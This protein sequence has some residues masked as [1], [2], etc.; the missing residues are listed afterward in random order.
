MGGGGTDAGG[1]GGQSGAGTDAGSGGVGGAVSL[2]CIGNESVCGLDCCG[3]GTCD[4][5]G[6]YTF[7]LEPEADKCKLTITE[8]G[9]S[10]ALAIMACDGSLAAV[11][12]DGTPNDQPGT[13]TGSGSTFTMSI[14]GFDHVC[15]V[16]PK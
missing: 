3:V 10:G 6:G 7:K 13:W 1:E 15:V 16:K 8:S 4:A 5:F 14:D 12:P 2:A 9:L 11:N